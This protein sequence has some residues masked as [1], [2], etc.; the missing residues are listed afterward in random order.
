[1]QNPE[2]RRRV[3]F[4]EDEP[5]IRLNYQRYFRDRLELAFAATGTE[6][7]VLL[8]EFRPDAVVLDLDVEIPLPQDGPIVVGG[9]LGALLVTLGQ[10]S[11]DLARET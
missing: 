11:Q 2:P 8:R 7:L 3:L 4:I 6:A 9:L 10:S 5:A 1:M